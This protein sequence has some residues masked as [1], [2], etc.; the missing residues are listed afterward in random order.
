MWSNEICHISL[1]K[2]CIKGAVIATF[3][4][5]CSWRGRGRGYWEGCILNDV[6]QPVI[7][8]MVMQYLNA[9]VLPIGVV[10]FLVARR[11]QIIHLSTHSIS[12]P[13]F[14]LITNR[15]H[16]KAMN[17][18]TNSRTLFCSIFDEKTGLKKTFDAIDFFRA[19]NKTYE[20]RFHQ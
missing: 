13:L 14:M 2:I 3:G 20:N 15:N 5:S 4:T 1:L 11:V 6:S 8:L 19:T 9:D 17:K 10:L 7:Q 12:G 18:L 16:M